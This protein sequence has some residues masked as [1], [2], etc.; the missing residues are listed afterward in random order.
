MVRL[1]HL[2]LH[3]LYITPSMSLPI[4]RIPAFSI[5]YMFSSVRGRGVCLLDVAARRLA[6]FCSPPVIVF[7]VSLCFSTV[8]CTVYLQFTVYSLLIIY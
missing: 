6:V 3:R 1:L 8:H 5:S 2:L 7:G 4:C